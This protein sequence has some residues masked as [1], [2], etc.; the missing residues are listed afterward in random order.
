MK[1]YED[2]IVCV[3]LFPVWHGLVDFFEKGLPAPI[4]GAMVENASLFVSY[5]QLQ[6]VI[7]WATGQSPL[8]D[9]TLPQLAIAGAGAGAVTSFVLCVYCHLK[10]SLLKKCL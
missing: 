6:H 7:R 5:S 4:V 2:S 8:Q 1:V 3:G 9:L 10:D